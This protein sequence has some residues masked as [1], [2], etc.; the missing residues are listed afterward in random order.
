MPFADETVL[1]SETFQQI[2]CSGKSPVDPLILFFNRIETTGDGVH[3][4]PCLALI[5]QS[6]VACTRRSCRRKRMAWKRS[7]CLPPAPRNGA[8]RQPQQAKK[9]FDLVSS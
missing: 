1:S 6:Q 9:N 5:C 4:C 3:L 2:H 7:R 8:L